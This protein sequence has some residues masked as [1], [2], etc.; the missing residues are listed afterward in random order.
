MSQRENN[1][2]Q[3]NALNDKRYHALKNQLT[4]IYKE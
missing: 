3:I 1:I 2:I 4:E